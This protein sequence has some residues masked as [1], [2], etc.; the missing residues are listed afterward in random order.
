[1]RACVYV[2]ACACIGLS[3]RVCKIEGQSHIIFILIALTLPK[4]LQQH[5]SAA[6]L[7]TLVSFFAGIRAIAGLD[8]N[9]TVCSHS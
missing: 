1:M 3:I 5:S 6:N 4:D 7:P 2:C 9:T 8:A